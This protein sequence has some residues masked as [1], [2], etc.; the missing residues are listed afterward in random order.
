MVYSKTRGREGARTLKKGGQAAE[1]AFSKDL[2]IEVQIAGSSHLKE[3]RDLH[4]KLDKGGLWP[5]GMFFSFPGT[6][7]S[8]KYWV[9]DCVYPTVFGIYARVT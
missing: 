5:I 1:I 9:D 6:V 2:C 4:A 7:C 8:M 3:R